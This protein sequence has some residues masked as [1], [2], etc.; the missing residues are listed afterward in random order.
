MILLIVVVIE[1]TDTSWAKLFYTLIS[2]NP[3]QTATN[4][5]NKLLAV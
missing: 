4:P 5:N 2:L 1:G 3:A